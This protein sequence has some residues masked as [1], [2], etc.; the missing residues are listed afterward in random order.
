MVENEE[1]RA[2]PNRKK[3]RAFFFVGFPTNSTTGGSARRHGKKEKEER[4]EG[5]SLPQASMDLR[6]RFSMGIREVAASTEEKREKSSS[7]I[8]DGES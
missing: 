3:S 7:K 6:R 2:R 5:R 4:K 1:E 8:V